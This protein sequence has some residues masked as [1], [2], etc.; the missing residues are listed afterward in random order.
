[1][2]LLFNNYNDISTEIT[3]NFAENKLLF[4]NSTIMERKDRFAAAFAYLKDNGIIRTQR[5]VAE[6]MQS[7]P[8]NV[9]N[10]LRGVPSVLTDNF[11]RRFCYA[12]GGIFQD[13]W[14][15]NGTGQML[16]EKDGI[17]NIHHFTNAILSTG[18][19]AQNTLGT[20]QERHYAPI[21]PETTMSTA[22]LDIQE[23]MTGRV[24]EQPVVFLDDD[25]VAMWCRVGDDALAPRITRG[26]LVALAKADRG[27]RRIVDGRVYAVNSKSFGMLIRRLKEEG[28]LIAYA[29]NPA[30]P[31]IPIDDDDVIRIH[32][33]VCLA[34]FSL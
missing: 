34:A 20:Q 7:T 9:S 15:L 16:C 3:T 17:S 10:A 30:Y 6:R 32:N 23:R 2:I 25:N 13:G 27:L 26:D 22:G 28:R 21:I 19:N 31:P 29:D 33:V 8:S 5:D 1:M 11:L 4:N 12:F 24:G 18:D 14:L